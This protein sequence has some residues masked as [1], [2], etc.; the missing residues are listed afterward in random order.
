MCYC[1]S[2]YSASK[3]FIKTTQPIIARELAFLVLANL[4]STMVLHWQS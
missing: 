2:P 1:L 3:F 4:A